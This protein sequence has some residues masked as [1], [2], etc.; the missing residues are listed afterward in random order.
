MAKDNVTILNQW[1]DWKD[2]RKSVYFFEQEGKQV[3]IPVRSVSQEDKDEVDRMFEL[4]PIPKQK[5]RDGTG[6]FVLVETPD[7]PAYIKAK[8]E[9]ESNRTYGLA[10]KMIMLDIPGDTLKEKIAA[11]KKKPIGDIW[12]LV[13]YGMDLSNMNLTEVVE[14]EK[15]D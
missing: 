9:A 11:L 5:V 8:E 13:K 1:T 12:Q 4:P 15:N 2:E 6:K 14:E 10:V 3:G 7:D